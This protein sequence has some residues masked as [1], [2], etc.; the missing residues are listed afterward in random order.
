[1]RPKLA[2]L[3]LLLAALA[4]SL[5]PN[6]GPSI[7]PPAPT[8]DLLATL[9]SENLTAAAQ[10]TP[11]SAPSA[12]PTLTPTPA[13]SNLMVVYAQNGNILLWREGTAAQSLTTSGQDSQP[14]L[15][16]DGQWAAFLR[17][18]E[19][20][21][22]K[23]DGSQER[24]LVNRAYIVSF[25]NANML[26]IRVSQ[27]DFLPGSHEILFELT[28]D[29]DVYPIPLNDLQRVSASV[30]NPSVILPPGSGGG[31]WFLSP[32]GQWL[33]LAQFDRLRVLRLDGSADRVVFKFKAVST[34]S[35]WA[36][37]PEV[38][39]RNDSA[40]FYTVIPA[41][42]ALEKPGEP[43]RFYYI[44]LS[45]EAAKLAE[46]V[47]VPVW[48]S[49]ARIAPNG[50]NVA[51]VKENGELR[52]LDASTAERTYAAAPGLSL[53]N[54]NPDSLRVA[55]TSGDPPRASLA[56]FGN[57]P[58]PLGDSAQFFD[59]RWVSPERFL[60]RNGDEL[61]LGQVSGPSSV[62]ATSI[63]DYDF[64]LLP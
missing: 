46:F 38:V 48:V 32:D 44:P 35:E 7:S 47:A 20:L 12:T 40:G 22:V 43:S 54:W 55:Y 53:L 57:P 64:V 4:C 14:R 60:Y 1:M 10:N 26:D 34:Y 19:L 36:Y 62:I 58:I 42:A 27:F 13:V 50:I 33:A 49:F 45:G 30:G 6:N 23:T 11:S 39:W 37:L 3:T 29:S 8:P 25:Q 56:A 59:L 9:V 31:R 63:S 51:Y 28:G 24:P 21:A 2:L 15:S 5:P 61:R 17:N 41:S 52:V 16:A 18:G